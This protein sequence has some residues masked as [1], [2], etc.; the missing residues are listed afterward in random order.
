MNKIN[1]DKFAYF[2]KDQIYSFCILGSEK[3]NISNITEL[4]LSQNEESDLSFIKEMKKL[5]ILNLSF[6]SNLTDIIFLKDLNNLQEL[7]LQG[8]SKITDLDI[9][10]YNKGLISLDIFKLN[11]IKNFSVLKELKNLIYLNTANC[12]IP[13]EDLNK[14]LLNLNKLNTFKLNRND[15]QPSEEII[16]NLKKNKLVNFRIN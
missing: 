11:N 6:C 2:N 8:C 12:R 9:L 3:H 4:S 1:L 16:F 10:K 13:T 15:P 5:K 14:I 7:Y